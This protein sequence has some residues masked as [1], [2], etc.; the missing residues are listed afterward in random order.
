VVVIP[1]RRGGF[2]HNAALHLV[3]RE[4][5]LARIADPEDVQGFVASVEALR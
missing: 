2:E 1:D 5:R 4:G 3:D